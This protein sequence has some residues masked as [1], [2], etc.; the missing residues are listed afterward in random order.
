MRDLTMYDLFIRNARIYPDRTA[1][2]QNDLRLS[3]KDVLARVDGLASGLAG[4]GIQKGDRIAVL[5]Y[6]DR[7]FLE[8][9][10]AASAIGAILVPINWRLSTEE[11]RHILLDCSP[12]AL[13]VDKAL[14]DTAAELHAS[15]NIP[16]L[17]GFHAD[18]PAP[19]DGLIRA[20]AAPKTQDVRSDDPFCIIYTAAVEGKARGAVLSHGN[21][22]AANMQT[23]AT[24]LLSPADSYLNMLPI[25]HITGLNLA[26]SVLHAGGKN[27]ILERFDARKTLELIDAESISII[28]SFPPILSNLLSEMDG[29]VFRLTSLRHVL[30]LDNPETIARFEAQTA[31]LFWTL[32]GQTETTGLVTFSPAR[33]KP[34]SA[35]RQGM[36][37]RMQLVDE[38][39]LPVA[40]GEPGEIV[41][42][43][44]LVFQGFWNQ[45]EANRFTFRNGWHHTGDMGKLDADGYLWFAGR[46]PEKELIKPGGEN[47]YP[48]EVEAVVLEHPDIEAVS[49]IGVPDPKF[50]EG[51]KAVC[52][53]KS[54]SSLSAEALIDFV[55]GKIARYKKP[56]YVQ[57]VDALPR[58]ASGAIDRKLVKERYGA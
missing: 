16:L 1:L 55:A 33:E 58:T 10:G 15:C 47:V 7:R 8:L 13:C 44:P 32:Y 41:V 31:A 54:G 57:F 12:K 45:Q 49:V 27:V 43:G 39:E 11:I 52:V 50:G 17:Y 9:F 34:G 38:R 40:V 48:A 51:I 14:A 28:G 56:R 19:L 26:L 23:I 42:Q 37:V 29:A 24:M 35:G 6:N 20:G 2:V 30:G 36:L 22:V 5:A 18:A 3:H 21:L 25:F 4:A 46:K 53:L